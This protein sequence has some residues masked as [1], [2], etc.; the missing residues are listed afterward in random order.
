MGVPYPTPLGPQTEADGVSR[1]TSG[2]LAD[3]GEGEEP[4]VLV[5]AGDRLVGPEELVRDVERPAAHLDDGEHV[6]SDA[7]ADHAERLGVD[8]V[9]AQDRAVGARVLLGDD[10]D[11]VEAV[12]DA[13]RGHLRL[14]VPQVALGDQHAGRGRRLG[15]RR[16]SRARPGSSSTG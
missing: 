10:L 4:V 3:R 6:G 14:L 5:G 1:R 9:P 2:H 16:W 13:R 7:V 12:G 15:A 11:A 8:A